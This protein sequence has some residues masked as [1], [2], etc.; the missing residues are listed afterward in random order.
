MSFLTPFY[1]LGLL[2]IALPIILHLINFRKPQRQAFSTLVFFR[3]LQR[4]SM[5]RLKLKKRLLLALR[6]ALLAL[7]AMALARPAFSPGTAFNFWS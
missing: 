3:R 5:K 4:S 2:A 1:L 6:I 7:L